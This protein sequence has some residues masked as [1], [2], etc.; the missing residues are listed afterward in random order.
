MIKEFIV[1]LF[2]IEILLMGVFSTLDI[3]L[4]YIMFEGILIPMFIIIGIWG[5]REE[6]VRAAFYFFFY[7]LVGSLF[8]LLCIFKIYE[9]TGTTNYQTLMSLEIP[10]H[11]QT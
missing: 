10:Y 6:K 11:L 5:S 1:G 9:L 3:L 4:F 2:F 7:T 8:M